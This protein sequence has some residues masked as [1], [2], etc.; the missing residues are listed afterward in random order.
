MALATGLFGEVPK[1]KI[2]DQILW[3]WLQAKNINMNSPATLGPNSC[4]RS[5]REER[6]GC[7]GDAGH[8]FIDLALIPYTLCTLIPQISLP[9]QK[10]G[11]NPQL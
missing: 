5:P 11:N 2:V 3:K 6:K 4:L 10:S 8:M 9:T 1:D 7:F